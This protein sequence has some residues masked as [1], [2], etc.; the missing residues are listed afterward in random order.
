MPTQ[1]QYHDAAED[2]RSQARAHRDAVAWSPR[3]PSGDFTG[4]GPIADVVD[5]SH[6]RVLRALAAAAV[7]LDAAASEC[8]RRAEVCRSFRVELDRFR[9]LPY[10]VRQHMAEP[11]RPATWVDL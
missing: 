4:P 2:L 1:H 8:E 11:V 9:S 5:E 7:E 6:R 10:E 3:S